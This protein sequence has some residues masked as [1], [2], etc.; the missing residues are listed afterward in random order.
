M[1]LSEKLTCDKHGEYVNIGVQIGSRTIYRRCPSCNNEFHAL[2][3][4]RKAKEAAKQAK[5]ER[6][7]IRA[8]KE[9]LRPLQYWLKRAQK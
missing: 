2:A 3:E 8:R 4:A 1:E 6:A 9:A 7:A 5:A